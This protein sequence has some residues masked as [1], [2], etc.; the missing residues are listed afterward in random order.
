MSYYDEEIKNQKEYLQEQKVGLEAMKDLI[1][2][3]GQIAKGCARIAKF[4]QTGTQ[5]NEDSIKR[6]KARIAELEK[7]KLEDA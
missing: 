7:Q 6:I 2:G 4:A 5:C 3:I 1:K